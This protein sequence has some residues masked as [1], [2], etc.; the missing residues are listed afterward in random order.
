[1]LRACCVK[2]LEQRVHRGE[3][4][5]TTTFVRPNRRC[6]WPLIEVDRQGSATCPPPSWVETLY[7]GLADNSVGRV[8]DRLLRHDLIIVDEIGF[9]SLD[10][11]GA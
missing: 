9:A 7:Q 6:G 4:I 2:W 10:P 3:L 5:E 11:T 8:I 1:L